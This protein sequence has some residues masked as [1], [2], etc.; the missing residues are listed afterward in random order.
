MHKVAVLPTVKNT[1]HK[2]EIE[3]S[4]SQRNAQEA[5]VSL[6]LTYPANYS[7]EICTSIQLECYR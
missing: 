3:T 2:R 7:V 1:R 4:E 6:T 5:D